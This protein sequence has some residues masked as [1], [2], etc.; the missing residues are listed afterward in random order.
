MS[1]PIN[2]L[3]PSWY[4]EFAN[5]FWYHLNYHCVHL[6]INVWYFIV[7]NIPSYRTLFTV[8]G[9]ISMHLSYGLNTKPCDF[10]AF[11]YRPY[12][13]IA[14]YIQPYKDLN[15][16]RCSTFIPFS[17][18]T[19]FYVLGSP[20]TWCPQIHLQLSIWWFLFWHISIEVCSRYIKNGHV[21]LFV[22]VNDKTGK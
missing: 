16:L 14:E 8:S 10:R 11:V 7:I 20:W 15:R 13:N 6:F 18:H 9:V 22:C 12:N 5:T 1:I 3:F 21:S 17:I 4:G 2:L 19:F